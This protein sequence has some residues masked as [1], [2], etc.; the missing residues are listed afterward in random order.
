MYKPLILITNDDG[1]FAEGIHRLVDYVADMADVIVVAP[2]SPR[3]GSSAA[4]TVEVPLRIREYPDYNGAKMLSINGTPVDCVKLAVNV[5]TP[6][7]PDLVLSGIN[8]GANTGSSVINSGTMGAAIEGAL[9]GI[10]SIGFSLVTHTPSATDF[11]ACREYVRKITE[12]VIEKGLPDGVCLNV[13]MPKGGEILGAR[14]GHSCLGRWMAEY[15]E[16]TD[17]AGRKFYMLTGTYK[18]LQPDD[19]NTDLYLLSQ[20]MVSIVPVATCRDYSGTLPDFSIN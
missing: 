11:D 18:N 2:D 5:V 16:Y 9:Q 7:R 4:I 8:H 20:K 6:R 15:N 3:S 17:P 19:H 13:N 14:I 1:I 12:S 10:P